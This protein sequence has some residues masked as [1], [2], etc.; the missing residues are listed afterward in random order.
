LGN[1]TSQT[2][3]QNEEFYRAQQDDS[4]KLK[5]KWKAFSETSLEPFGAPQLEHGR[6]MRILERK[7]NDPRDS[8]GPGV[9]NFVPYFVS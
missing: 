6:Q 3:P 1:S 2:K 5:V 9:P 8:E 4:T 7:L